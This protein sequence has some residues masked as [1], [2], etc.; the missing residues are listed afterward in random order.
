M[1]LLDQRPVFQHP[2]EARP[3]AHVAG[4]AIAARAD[5]E[6]YG[7]LVAVDPQLDHVLQLAAGVALLPE[8]IA[9]PAEVVRDLGVDRQ[10]QR[11]GVHPG[12]H[13]D[14]AGVGVLGDSHDQAIAVEARREGRAP[15]KFVL[16]VGLGEQV[17]AHAP[18]MAQP[19]SL[20]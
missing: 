9:R 19:L 17:G 6:Q 4:P 11:L 5:L 15:L 3:E 12:Q 18:H 10:L 8:F 2:I 16:G 14:L 7:V 13:Q 1:G 20:R